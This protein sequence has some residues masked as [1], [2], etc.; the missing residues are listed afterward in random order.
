MKLMGTLKL[1][2]LAKIGPDRVSGA[3]AP[4]RAELEAA[5]WTSPAD[6]AKQYPTALIDKS[7]I[8]IL[9]DDGY[10]VDLI[11][12]YILGM[13]FIDHA[14]SAEGSCAVENSKGGKAA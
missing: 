7:S 11:A 13:V 2:Q 4:L 3:V 10:C 14:G 9:L 5:E 8:R 12:D 1:S 6:V